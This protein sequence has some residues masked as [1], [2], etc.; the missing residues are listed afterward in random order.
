MKFEAEEPKPF[1]EARPQSFR[2]QYLGTP[3]DD[4]SSILKEVEIEVLDVSAAIIA[5]ANLVWPPH[6]TAL[7]I[8]D[9]ES[10]EVYEGTRPRVADCARWRSRRA[11]REIRSL[12]LTLKIKVKIGFP[13]S[14]ADNGVG[15]PGGA[16]R[17]YRSAGRKIREASGPPDEME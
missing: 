11:D 3:S 2:V 8:L 5:A 1:L 16:P 15:I 17:K 13:L 7:R 9:R 14:S 6:T 4:R 10:R 12:R